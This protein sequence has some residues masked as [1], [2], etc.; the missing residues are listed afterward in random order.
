M[1]NKLK[2]A[3]IGVGNMGKN[4]ARIYSELEDVSL[5]AV[6]DVNT[7]IGKN[8]ANEYKTVY[9]SNYKEM[10]LKENP[11]IVSIVVPTLFHYNI[12]EGCLENGINVIL[13]KPITMNVSDGKKLLALAKKNKVKFLVGHIERHNSAVQKVKEM[14]DRGELGKII[15]VAARRVGGFPPQVKDAD[16][17]IDLAIHD[18]DIV[19]YLLDEL[20]RKIFVNRNKNHIKDRYDSVEFFLKYKNASAYIQANWITPTKIRKLNITGSEG[21]LEM[22]YINQTIDFY[23]SNYEKFQQNRHDYSDYILKFSNSERLSVPVSKKEPLKEEIKY[24]I[25]CVK[26]NIAINPNFALEAL[27]IA[28]YE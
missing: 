24:F 8:I 22:D 5:V 14:I 16:V 9:Y 27:K 20:P 21:Y 3:V 1:K 28:L 2:C 4:H 19:N 26:K 11:D 23:K 13:E 18:I 17:S 7:K 25:E 12:A 10:I 15:A 6:V